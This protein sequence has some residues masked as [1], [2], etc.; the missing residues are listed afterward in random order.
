MYK[1]DLTKAYISAVLFT[2]IVGFSFL[3][4][5]ICVPYADTLHVLVHRF[6]FALVAL[7]VLAITKVVKIELKGKPKKGLLITSVLYNVFILFQ[8][9]G[10]YYCTSIEGS[11]FFAM[12]PAMVQV[13]AAVFLKEKPTWM[14][15]CFILLS[16]SS[17]IVMVVLGSSQITFN[18]LGV[19]LMLISSL[20]MAVNNVYTRHIRTQYKPIEISTAIIVFGTVLFNILFI[21]RGLIFGNAQAYFEPFQHT[22]FIIAA[23]YLGVGCILAS[24]QIMAYL[25]SKLQSAKAAVFGNVSTAISIVA[26]ALILGEPLYT[27]HII[28]SI[29]IVTGALGINFAGRR[30]GK[31]EVRISDGK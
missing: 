10:L 26:G 12:V 28:C 25:Q 19:V 20:A 18:P 1:N 5:K 4:I 27:Y 24:A 6:N 29:F 2:F 31:N 15:V 22:E 23:C 9:M 11:V 21:G 14:Q 13:I 8:V 7:I 3:G 16:V 30:G 17:L